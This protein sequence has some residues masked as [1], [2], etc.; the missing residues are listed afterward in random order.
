MSIRKC[1]LMYAHNRINTSNNDINNHTTLSQDHHDQYSSTNSIH[2]NSNRQNSYD[3]N[4]RIMYDKNNEDNN[5]NNNNTINITN[6]PLNSDTTITADITTES[7]WNTQWHL[8]STHNITYASHA[9]T[10]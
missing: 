7:H 8:K 3:N 4:S 1:D 10:H 6:P 2:T 5:P 9:H